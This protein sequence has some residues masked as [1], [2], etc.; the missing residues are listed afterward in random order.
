MRALAIGVLFGVLLSLMVL[1]AAAPA[2]AQEQPAFQRGF[3]TLAFRAPNLVGEPLE[4]EY[5]NGLFMEQR[6]TTG[7]LIWS[8]EWPAQWT[9]E[10][11]LDHGAWITGRGWVTW[12]S[13]SNVPPPPAVANPAGGRTLRVRLTYYVL[14]GRMANGQFVHHGAAA[15]SSNIRMGSTVVFPGG[16]T[17][18]CKDTGRLGNTGWVDVWQGQALTRRYGDY[19]LVTVHGG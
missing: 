3:A 18:V 8:E 5:Y 17:V 13:M 11:G 9:S 10:D 2:N 7:R 12:T 1:L 6:T 16:E 15:C 14:A 19:A 4:D